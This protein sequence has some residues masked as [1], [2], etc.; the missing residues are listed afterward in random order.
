MNKNY[1]FEN[2]EDVPF[3]Y[4]CRIERQVKNYKSSL[5]AASYFI[6]NILNTN[7][8]Y[9]K[10]VKEEYTKFDYCL[11]FM[12]QATK[13]E[14]SLVISEQKVIIKYNEKEI[15]FKVNWDEYHIYVE[16]IAYQETTNQ[17]KISECLENHHLILEI[18]NNKQKYCLEIPYDVNYFIDFQ[19]FKT[20]KIES[21]IDLKRVYFSRFFPNQTSYEKSISTHLTLWQKDTDSEFV[22]S[23]ELIII[24]GFINKYKISSLKN[25]ILMSI[26]G[27]PNE[28]GEIK[29][30][31]YQMQDNVD[32]NGEILK[33]YK[34]SLK[35][36]FN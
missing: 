27:K 17:S 19:Y 29:I 5:L 2:K 3:I 20:Q 10:L 33:L 23:D 36:N 4:D 1:T 28:I 13:E 32:L 12:A 21:I 30:M 26:E 7:Q 8:F 14:V 22:L 24:D 25:G 16:I 35:M 11:N 6:M 31:N 34:K 15:Q 9:L 18:E